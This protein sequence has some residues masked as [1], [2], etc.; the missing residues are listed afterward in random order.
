MR[1][2][3]VLLIALTLALFIPHMVAADVNVTYPQ[4][5]YELEQQANALIFPIGPDSYYFNGYDGTSARIGVISDLELRR[6]TIL[7]EKQNELLAE[8]NQLMQRLLD[9]QGCV[10]SFD[11]D[12]IHSSVPS[13]FDN[14][15]TGENNT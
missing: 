12:R 10:Q 8:N 11:I 4:E 9:S 13:W 14:R 3:P 1:S 6:Q 2:M 5:Y 15:T 7:M